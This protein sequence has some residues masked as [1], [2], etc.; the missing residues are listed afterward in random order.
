M[1][2]TVG[3]WA[4]LLVKR[5]ESCSQ[6]NPVKVNLSMEMREVEEKDEDILEEVVLKKVLR[7]N[8]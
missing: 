1:E 2:Q 4:L 6:R 3:M 8:P 7:N 5:L